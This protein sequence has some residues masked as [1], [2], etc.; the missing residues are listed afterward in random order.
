MPRLWPV[1]VASA[2]SLGLC[3]FE[4]PAP[5]RTP[6]PAAP[7]PPLSF[8]S[9]TLRVPGDAIVAMLNDRTR[10]QLAKIQGEDVNCLIQKCELDL[11]A[12]RTGDI[13]GHAAGSGMQLNLP[14]AL[15]AHL[16]FNAKYLK[17]A[18]DAAAQGMTNAVTQLKLQPDWRMQSHTDG[19]V[20]LSDAK[21]KLG[22]LKMSVTQ[23]WNSNAERLSG[24]IFQVIDKRVVSA[25]K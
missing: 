4:A 14:F 22:P 16:A 6:P 10:A 9:A 1:F 12:T 2:L 3:A 21:L 5:Q 19:E 11:I 18:G 20:H 13:T 24:P 23:L 7:R 25:F 8:V 17:T 15:H